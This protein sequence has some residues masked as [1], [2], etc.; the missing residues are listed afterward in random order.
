[1]LK[2]VISSLHA[3]GIKISSYLDNIFLCCSSASC[4]K[5]QITSTLNLLISLGFTPNYKNSHLLPSQEITHL[6]YTW[7]SALMTIYLHEEKV[8]KTKRK[9]SHVLSH[10]PSLQEI[11]A[12]LGIIVSHCTDFTFAPLFYRNLQLQFCSSIKCKFS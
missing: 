5:F 7:N 2:P 3:E 4:L 10:D 6:G 1:M 12:L 11:S 9:A 8:I